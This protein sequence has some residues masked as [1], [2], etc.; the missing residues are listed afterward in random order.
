MFYLLVF[1]ACALMWLAFELYWQAQRTE[2]GLAA[3]SEQTRK[4]HAYLKAQ[5]PRGSANV[6]KTVAVDYAAGIDSGNDWEDDLA[7]T[8]AFPEVSDSGMRRKTK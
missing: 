4:S 5:L 3:G 8:Q 1:M 2:A 7:A 6:R